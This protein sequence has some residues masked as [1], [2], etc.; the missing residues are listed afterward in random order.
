MDI[1]FGIFGKSTTKWTVVSP[2]FGR[3]TGP[4]KVGDAYVTE[5]G[6]SSW[7]GRARNLCVIINK[8]NMIGIE[9]DI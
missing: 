5:W 9:W 3:G 6:S 2:Q 8:I 7:A 4:G 1:S